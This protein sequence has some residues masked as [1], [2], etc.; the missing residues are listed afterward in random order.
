MKHNR[1]RQKYVYDCEFDQEEFPLI[2]RDDPIPMEY[3]V[4]YRN[5]VSV[6][7]E[8]NKARYIFASTLHDLEEKDFLSIL[9]KLKKMDI[10]YLIILND[11]FLSSE[12]KILKE[13]YRCY[14][15]SFLQK[16]QGYGLKSFIFQ[17][18]T[19]K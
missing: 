6:F 13:G 17:E 18:H 14:L 5:E 1:L 4:D 3:V 16:I 9:A 8:L 2:R 12:N 19:T 7:D 15:Y 11:I 10:Q